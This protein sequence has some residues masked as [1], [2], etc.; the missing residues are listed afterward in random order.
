MADAREPDKVLCTCTKQLLP[1][2]DEGVELLCRYCKRVTA[3]RF[4]EM[5]TQ[6]GCVDSGGACFE[7]GNAR[8]VPDRI[9]RESLI[10][11]RQLSDILDVDRGSPIG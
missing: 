8:G 5:A 10:R 7:L 9:H 4:E 11:Y 2:S 6:P 1:F 3:A